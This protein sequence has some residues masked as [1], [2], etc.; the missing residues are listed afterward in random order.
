[1]RKFII[2]GLLM[3]VFNYSANAGFVPP[4]DDPYWC[5][6]ACIDSEYAD[7]VQCVRKCYG[8]LDSL[9][10]D[11]SNDSEFGWFVFAFRKEG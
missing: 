8:D 3:V 10:A 2:F 1:M 11:C 4:Q 5:Y 6:E 7:H 9:Q